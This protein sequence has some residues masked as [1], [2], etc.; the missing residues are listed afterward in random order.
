VRTKITPLPS[1]LLPRSDFHFLF[2]VA[3]IHHFANLKKEGPK[4]HDQENLFLEN[5][6]RTHHI[7]RKKVVMKLSR[8]FEGFGQ[9]FSF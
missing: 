7:L 8:F 4:Q 2:F 5:F 3:K 9:I 6:Q 1:L